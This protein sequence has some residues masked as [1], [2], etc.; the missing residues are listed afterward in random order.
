[1]P[2]LRD[3]LGPDGAL[4]DVLLGWSERRARQLRLALRPV[5]PPGS[6]RAL[7]DTGAEMTCVDAGL[8]R[9]L[10]LPFSGSSRT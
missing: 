7:L 3:I 2:V 8:I 1:M 10:S 4:I 6:A 9:T 5:P